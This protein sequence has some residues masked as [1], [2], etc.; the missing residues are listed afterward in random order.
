MG[1]LDRTQLRP[2]KGKEK[3]LVI[4][5]YFFFFPF[6][7]WCK[8]RSWGFP[9]SSAGRESACNVGHPSSIPRLRRSPRVG[10]DYPLQYSGASLMAQMVKNPPAIWVTWVWSLHQEIPGGGHGNPLHSSCLENPHGQRSLAGYG[11]WG[12]QEADVTE[13][14]GTAQHGEILTELTGTGNVFCFSLIRF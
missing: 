8:E 3:R 12:H 1:V 10:I 2:N 7:F 6:S 11:P 13:W 14:L 5:F 9:G 4:F